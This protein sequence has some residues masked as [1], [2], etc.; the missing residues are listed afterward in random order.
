MLS[1]YPQEPVLFSASEL[2]ASHYWPHPQRDSTQERADGHPQFQK[3]GL[4]ATPAE[5]G[6]QG[7]AMLHSSLPRLVNLPTYRMKGK[8]QSI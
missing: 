2:P 1:R 8:G 3:D 7:L 4:L 6:C 5:K